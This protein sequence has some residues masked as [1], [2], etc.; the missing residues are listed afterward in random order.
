MSEL[1][2]IINHCVSE[3]LETRNSKNANNRKINQPWYTSFLHSLKC[4]KERAF[5]KKLITNKESDKKRHQQLNN[6]YFKTLHETRDKYY[7]NHFQINIKNSK[8]TW[9]MINKLLGR[10]KKETAC[11]S[12]IHNYTTITDLMHIA[13]TFITNIFLQ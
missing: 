2:N 13:D 11:T 1:T 12:L 9:V 3:C 7:T 6:Q 8:A 5:K 10:N 4:K